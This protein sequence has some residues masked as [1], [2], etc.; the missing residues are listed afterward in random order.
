MPGPD[1][2][3]VL[4]EDHRNVERLFDQFQQTNDPEVALEIC[5]ELTVHATAEEE[6]V[7]PV[8]AT[9]VH[10]GHAEDARS[11]HAQAKELISQIEGRV[12]EGGDVASVVAELQQLMQH[13]VEQEESEVFPE[14]R[15]QVPTAIETMGADLVERKKTLAAQ[16]REFRESGVSRKNIEKAPPTAGMG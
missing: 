3:T 10:P 8:L 6:L 11:E 9:K 13:H 2:F 16:V 5:D 7:Y 1:I 4:T 15:R 12:A 14:M